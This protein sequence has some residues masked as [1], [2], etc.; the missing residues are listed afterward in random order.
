MTKKIDDRIEEIL[1]SI[2]G[3]AFAVVKETARRWA[4]NG[5]LEVT[6]QDFDHELASKKDGIT[7]EGE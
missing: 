4:E 3:E 7:F 1:E 6:A 5:K 2:M